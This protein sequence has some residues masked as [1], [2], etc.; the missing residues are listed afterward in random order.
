MGIEPTTLCLEAREVEILAPVES[1]RQFPPQNELFWA[2]D[3]GR[4]EHLIEV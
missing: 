1:T 2:S 3:S 4:A